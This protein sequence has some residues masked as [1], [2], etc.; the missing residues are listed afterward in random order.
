MVLGAGITKFLGVV[1]V[2]RVNDEVDDLGQILSNIL[3]MD[4]IGVAKVTK[5]V[6]FITV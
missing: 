2:D 6:S 1:A 5:E 4:L 3:E